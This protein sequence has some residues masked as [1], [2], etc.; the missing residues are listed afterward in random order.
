MAGITI[1]TQGQSGQTSQGSTSRGLAG[2]AGPQ[3][4]KGDEGDVGP[5]GSK[6][7]TGDT[8]SQG[9]PG[10]QGTQGVQGPAGA[11]GNVGVAGPVG[12]VG[13]IGPK[14]PAGVPGGNTVLYLYDHK[15]SSPVA[16]ASG[17]VSFYKNTFSD[18]NKIWI[19]HSGVGN[20]NNEKW[21]NSILGWNGDKKQGHLRISEAGD[22]NKSALFI[23]S[24]AIGNSGN[25]S[26]IPVNYVSSYS[27]AIVDTF[28]N[29]QNLALS[30][31]SIGDAGLQGIQGLQG[32]IGPNGPQGEIG[33]KGDKGDVGLQGV[34]GPAGPKGSTGDQGIKGDKGDIGPKGDG[35]KYA[36]TSSSNVNPSTGIREFILASSTLS[37]TPGQFVVIA[38]IADPN[39]KMEGSVVSYIAGKLTVNVS[40]ANGAGTSRSDWV[41]NLGGAAGPRGEKGDLGLS[42]PVGAQGPVGVVGGVTYHIAVVQK[43]ANHPLYNQ[44]STMGFTICDDETCA[45]ST[46]GKSLHLVRG[47]TYYFKQKN[48]SNVGHVLYISTTINGGGANDRYQKNSL[49]LFTSTGTAGSDRILTFTVPFDAPDNLFY[50]CE[51]HGKMGG[52]IS[53]GNVGPKGDKGDQGNQGLVGA[54]GATGVVGAKG[55]QGVKGDQGGVGLRGL[56]GPA[57]PEGPQGAKGSVGDQGAVGPQGQT[58]VQGLNGEMG[59]NWKGSWND[60]VNYVFR[61]AVHHDGS[62]WAAIANSGPTTSAK[63]PS[64]TNAAHWNL[65]AKKGDK[66]DKGD[67]GLAGPAGPSGPETIVGLFKIRV[68]S[69]GTNLRFFISRD[70]GGYEESPVIDLYKG[71][72]YSFDQSDSTNAGRVFRFSQFSDGG[73]T[74]SNPQGL[75][76]SSGYAYSGTE[77]SNGRIIFS[78]P[79]DAPDKL[80][81]FSPTTDNL[82]GSSQVNIKTVSQGAQGAAGPEGQTGTSSQNSTFSSSTPVSINEPTNIVSSNKVV[83]DES[84]KKFGSA[85]AR[86]DGSSSYLRVENSKDWVFGNG[87][88]FELDGWFYFN[89]T[90]TD[91]ALF[92]NNDISIKVPQKITSPD[93]MVLKELNL[94][95]FSSAPGIPLILTTSSYAQVPALVTDGVAANRYFWLQDYNYPPWTS[96]QNFIAYSKSNPSARMKC[97]VTVL[98]RN[99][100]NIGYISY[101]CSEFSGSGAYTDWVLVAS[102]ASASFAEVEVKSVSSHYFYAPP[103]AT[104]LYQHTETNPLPFPAS[105]LVFSMPNHR[106]GN[107]AAKWDVSIVDGSGTPLTNTIRI[108]DPTIAEQKISIP[109]FYLPKDRLLY[110]LVKGFAILPAQ[111]LQLS[112]LPEWNNTGIGYYPI[113]YGV[114]LKFSGIKIHEHRISA[115]KNG[116]I[117]S[118]QDKLAFKYQYSFSNYLWYHLAF[119]KRGS[120]Y[121]FYVDGLKRPKIAPV[122]ATSSPDVDY[123][124]LQ[125]TV[126]SQGTS[127]IE[128]KYVVPK[129]GLF[130]LSKIE[131][132]S[133]AAT[134]T[135]YTFF[136]IFLQKSGSTELRKLADSNILS[137]NVPANTWTEYRKNITFIEASQGDTIIVK[138]WPSYETY[139]RAYSWKFYYTEYQPA[140][141]FP[142]TLNASTFS[143]PLLIGSSQKY[144]G[145]LITS[146]RLNGWA[147][148]IRISKGSARYAGSFAPA[149]E[150]HEADDNTKLLLHFD[151]IIDSSKNKMPIRM[152]GNP[153]LIGNRVGGGSV[154]LDGGLTSRI[155]SDDHDPTFNFQDKNFTIDFW[156]K[157]TLSQIGK[158]EYVLGQNDQSISDP[159]LNFLFKFGTDNK[160]VFDLRM[161]S[162]EVQLPEVGG[163][164]GSE[165]NKFH[166]IFK[167]SVGSKGKYK[168]TIDVKCSAGC[169][170]DMSHK[171]VFYKNPDS[172]SPVTLATVTKNQ[173]TTASW[174]PVSN[175]DIDIVG[176]ISLDVGDVISCVLESTNSLTDHLWKSQILFS[177]G[178]K[179]TL[180]LESETPITD[181]IWHHYV[182]QRRGTYIFVYVDGKRK[183]THFGAKGH[184]NNSSSQFSI[185]QAGENANNKFIGGLDELRICHKEK[186]PTNGFSLSTTNYAVDVD[187]KLLMHFDK[188]IEDSTQEA[189]LQPRLLKMQNEYSVASTWSSSN[190]SMI[191]Y[192]FGHG[193]FYYTAPYPGLVT[194]YI[195]RITGQFEFKV[196]VH[197]NGVL[198][199]PEIVMPFSSAYWSV[200]F[201]LKK[202]DVVT[203]NT[204]HSKSAIVGTTSGNYEHGMNFI[205]QA[206][207]LIDSGKWGHGINMDLLFNETEFDHILIEDS[208]RFSLMVNGRETP[209]KNFT[210]ET[211]IQLKNLTEVHAII[212]QRESESKY[213]KLYFHPVNGLVYEH[214]DSVSNP[215]NVNTL[216][217]SQDNID[218]WSSKVWYHI[219]LVRNQDNEWTLFKGQSGTR[220][221]AIA[222]RLASNLIPNL[223]AR[224]TIGRSNLE[225]LRGTLD[226]FMFS[227]SAKYFDIE[228]EV[229]KDAFVVKDDTVF[230]LRMQDMHDGFIDSSNVR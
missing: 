8:G 13:S 135:N 148:E 87:E 111:T 64:A 146:G 125:E 131:M 224:I 151:K 209:H 74:V 184:L 134:A 205:V 39:A 203:L 9:V 179:Q 106:S 61:D 229:P 17:D 218:D 47:F 206:D 199:Y 159:S 52:T 152:I 7:N 35:D 130:S 55:E 45:S 28:S 14:G 220:G 163:F 18:V 75:T 158:L 37:Y 43:P 175:T 41:V 149:T 65:L 195:K 79:L 51:L 212:E 38:S 194:L 133:P 100:S 10:T 22:P 59:L 92:D 132:F 73:K 225:K 126:D 19:H 4:P 172:A 118:T 157:R 142:N 173:T 70:G 116:V 187:T 46:A 119:V 182:L 115:H 204:T 117:I 215:D 15:E 40:E 223:S 21:V 96:G 160:P 129:N 221:G 80:Y 60:T 169:I 86:F 66:G 97:V 200:N 103:P 78:V 178:Q 30:F 174:T 183:A 168:V 167:Y 177:D 161:E 81:Y 180:S 24:G 124:V 108:N 49:D 219:A 12:G 23:V 189:S 53:V 76:Y 208:P 27:P 201:S 33:P 128:S 222:Y 141:S 91:N 26:T 156:A 109:A 54:Q 181:V 136:Q 198:K 104:S 36:T 127:I 110:I 213:W 6:G 5:Q 71:F 82:G 147:D 90:A 214:K 72:N 114:P 99:N 2:P 190:L 16:V 192:K 170:N 153:T 84:F 44:G 210:I 113:L 188:G 227:S 154:Y 58:G 95:E 93:T 1:I 138:I 31:V 226:D 196:N 3:G 32:I 11:Q 50:S 193:S 62:S 69:N 57:G 42:G 123:V 202:G 88:D 164:S 94:S 150:T 67:M 197:V 166:N 83:I 101:T 34:V 185:G 155:W 143:L 191:P 176:G 122:L 77:G 121:S 207:L 171:Y 120:D 85:S 68:M 165:S 105:E 217:L 144:D 20:A 63:T 140:Q 56:A 48:V 112:Y 228:Y 89:N 230:L 25:Y 162:K 29:D 102:A 216:V 98:G 186:F 211:W 107:L 137:P 139:V 145:T